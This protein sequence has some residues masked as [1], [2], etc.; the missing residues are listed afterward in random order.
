MSTT[1]ERRDVSGRPRLGF[2]GLGWIGRNRCAALLKNGTAEMVGYVDQDTAAEAA[3]QQLAPNARRLA[4]LDELLDLKPDG[5]VIATPS[6]LHAHEALAALLAGCVVFCQKPLGRTA[7]ECRDIVSTA[8]QVNRLLDVDFCYRR[9]QGVADMRQ[10]VRQGALGEV[11]AAHLV[12]HNAY[13][14]DKP[15][16]YDANQ[17][18]GGCLMD[19]GIHL[20]DL[21]LW[22]MGSREVTDVS[23]RMLAKGRPLVN[24]GR[25][26][27]DYAVAQLD[28]ANGAIATLSCSWGLPA[29]QDAVIE[30]SF[31]GTEGGVTWRNVGGSFYD[32]QVERL[33]GTAREV[34]AQPPDDWGGRTAVAWAERLARDRGFDPA[35][36]DIVRVA[37]VLDAIYAAAGNE[38]MKGHT[39]WNSPLQRAQPIMT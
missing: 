21:L 35:A 2:L 25:D 22:I 28:L 8:R 9:V 3:A 30:A 19:L 32:F 26:V 14:P 6:A 17:S 10:L 31:Y 23:A 37:E 24:R 11:Y 27:E 5:V 34:M 15:W 39:P 4:S 33:R 12:F 16:Y 1:G 36:E 7:E 29:G 13:G 18:G 20:V 38:P